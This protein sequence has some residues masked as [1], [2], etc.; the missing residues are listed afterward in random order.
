MTIMLTSCNTKVYLNSH[1]FE[2]QKRH[3]GISDE[4]IELALLT[5]INLSEEKSNEYSV[6]IDMGTNI[7]NNSIVHYKPEINIRQPICFGFRFGRPSPSPIEINHPGF[8]TKYFFVY[9]KEYLGDWFLRSAYPIGGP[10]SYRPGQEPI[11]N[12]HRPGNYISAEKR[13]I[14]MLRRCKKW[15]SCKI[16]QH[17]A[18]IDGQMFI[19]TWEDVL[20]KYYN[21]YD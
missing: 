6:S 12:A 4:L 7:G 2:H 1:F 20:C 5:I 10:N 18:G 19:S 21:V 11:S 14:E 16:A 13:R 8:P 15:R 17:T 3:P 9:L